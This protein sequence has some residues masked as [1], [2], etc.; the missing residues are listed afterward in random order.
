MSRKPKT[1]SVEVFK[2]PNKTF[3]KRISTYTV[4]GITDDKGKVTPFEDGLAF[5]V[6]SMT[7]RDALFL[8]SKSRLESGDSDPIQEMYW[9]VRL[10]VSGWVGLKYED[11]SE[12]EPTYESID[13]MGKDVQALS[14]ESFDALPIDVSGHLAMCIRMVTHMTE[15]ELKKLDFMSP[16]QN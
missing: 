12:V 3:A 7:G 6:R 2:T 15:V 10:G 14:S 16:L 4:T 11:G 8:S 5:T 1:Q 9:T 13:V